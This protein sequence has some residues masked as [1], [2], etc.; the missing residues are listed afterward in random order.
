MRTLTATLS[1]EQKDSSIAPLYRIVLSRTGQTTVTYDEDRVLSVDHVEEPYHSQAEV[2]LNNSDLNITT[3]FKGYKA[4]ISYGM[5]TS[6]GAERSACAPLWVFGQQNHSS[7]GKLTVT[8]SLR[9][10]MDLIAEDKANAQYTL[11]SGDT[12]TVKTLLNAVLGATIAPFN[13]CIAYTATYDSEDS[14]IDVFQP[15]DAFD[16]QLNDTR[17]AVIQRLLFFTRSVVRV[18]ANEA[19]H[20]RA[21][22]MDGDTWVALT[23]Y[24]LQDYAEP[25]VVNNTFAFRCTTAG[26]TGAAEPTWPTV[27]GGTVTDGTVV[28]TAVGFDDEYRMNVANQ[29]PIF[30]KATRNRLTLPNYISVKSHPSTTDGFSGTAEDTDSSDI[31]NMEKREHYYLRVDSNAQAASVAKAILQTYR[32]NAQRGAALVPVNVGQEV[33]DYVKFT[34]SRQND[35]RTGNVG[36]LQRIVGGGRWEMQIAFGDTKLGGYLGLL[37][38]LPDVEAAG[39]RSEDVNK[40]LNAIINQVNAALRQINTAL[41][42]LYTNQNLITRSFSQSLLELSQATQAEMVITR[43]RVLE[44]LRIPV[45]SDKFD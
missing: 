31:T 45:G 40:A 44:R 14:L 11:E 36:S 17:L 39:V 5:T 34:D 2:V 9:G 37:P 24:V 8:L 35:V 26:T 20:F 42:T 29:H 16:I 43:L 13:H 33:H 25:T 23:A 19:F 4:V 21:P 15:A 7:Q 12:Q 10:T 22:T 6:S 38:D 27:A 32:L 41:Q 1:A 18:E 3:D 30:A 28:W